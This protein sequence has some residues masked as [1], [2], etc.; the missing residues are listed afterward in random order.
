MAVTTINLTD[1]VSTLVTKTNTISSDVGD[2]STLV[3]GDDNVV[4]A[5][6]TVRN[7]VNRFDESAEIIA[8]AREAI[9]AD[10]NDS[11]TGVYLSW[12]SASGKISL[13]N[14]YTFSAGD[15]LDYDDRGTYNITLLG[16]TTSMIADLNV[17]TGKIANLNVTNGKVANNTLTSSKFNSVVS[18]QILDSTGTPVKTLYSPG[19]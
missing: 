15:G 9:N 8:L 16:V 17:T 4:D 3:T 19:S 5:I 14:T 7:I 6:N 11:A 12:D 10:V 13:N 18:L 1:P 2:V